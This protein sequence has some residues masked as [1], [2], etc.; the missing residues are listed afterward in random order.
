MVHGDCQWL[1]VLEVEASED[2]LEVC[3]LGQ[4][5]CLPDKVAGDFNSEQPGAWTQVSKFVF[6]IH[7]SLQFIDQFDHLQ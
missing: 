6:P 3:A 1:E 7:F 2:Y 5:N 4:G